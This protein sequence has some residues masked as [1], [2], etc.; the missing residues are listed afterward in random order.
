MIYT[1]IYKKEKSF[2]PRK[3]EMKNIVK[4]RIEN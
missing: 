4:L 1:G 2:I 3:I